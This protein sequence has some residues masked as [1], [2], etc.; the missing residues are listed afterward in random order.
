[1]KTN[2]LYLLM[3][4]GIPVS[5]LL[6][7]DADCV[8]CHPKLLSN[9]KYDKDHVILKQCTKCHTKEKDE[10]THG[11]CGADCWQCH[12][13]HNVSRVYIPE[14]EALSKCIQCHLSID[15]KFFKLPASNSFSG[16]TL[17]DSL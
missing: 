12:D 6:A 14:H 17:I 10:E 11:A 16:D 8:A 7:C 9:G 1:M 5:S 2:A 13:I 4:I 3:I 15:K